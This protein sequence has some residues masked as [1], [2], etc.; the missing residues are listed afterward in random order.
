MTDR[1]SLLNNFYSSFN[2]DAR[3]TKCRSGELE[4]ITTMHFIGKPA[5]GDRILEVGAGTGRY[6]I[7]L[8]HSNPDCQVTAL[9]LVPSNIEVMK[10]NMGYLKNMEALQGDALD[11]SRFPDKTFDQTLVLGPLYHHVHKLP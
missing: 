9:E 8:A 3:L 5:A 10:K 7:A 1:I 4:Y 2:E 6:S 11:L